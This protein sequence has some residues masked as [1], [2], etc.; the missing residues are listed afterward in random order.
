MAKYGNPAILY[1]RKEVSLD[2][3]V[4]CHR[5]RLSS[6]FEF[7]HRSLGSSKA[8]LMRAP[9][10]RCPSE[11]CGNQCETCSQDRSGMGAQSVSCTTIN[12]RFH[13][14]HFEW[15]DEQ[16]IL[17]SAI[18]FSLSTRLKCRACTLIDSPV[19]HLS[20]PIPICL[21]THYQFPI[22]VSSYLGPKIWTPGPKLDSRV[23]PL[24]EEAPA[25]HV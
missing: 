13:L 15:R 16:Q 21:E 2:I 3:L 11:G 24:S 6:G 10:S 25:I 22:A 4:F 18:S 23:Y 14:P 1:I 9:F 8:M 7:G 12:S 5:R 17:P 20:L 19:W